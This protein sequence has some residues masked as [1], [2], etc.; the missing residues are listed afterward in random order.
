MKSEL[1]EARISW[2]P[3][4]RKP[5]F[6]KIQASESMDFLKSKRPEAWIF[7]NPI[8]KAKIPEIVLSKIQASRVLSLAKSK[9]PAGGFCKIQARGGLDFQKSKPPKAWTFEHSGLRNLG[10]SKIRASGGM[11]F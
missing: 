9:L 7:K 2:N 11:V 5:G 3:D 6:A 4:F 1:P 10:F 8:R